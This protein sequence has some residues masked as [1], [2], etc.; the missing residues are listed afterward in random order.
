VSGYVPFEV[1]ASGAALRAYLIQSGKLVPA[2]PFTAS[3][4][5]HTNVLILDTAGREAAAR[6]IADPGHPYAAPPVYGWEPDYQFW[7]R[8]R[9][10]KW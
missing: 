3:R 5:E 6:T 10:V 1:T 9:G 8:T 2:G 7:L 4:M